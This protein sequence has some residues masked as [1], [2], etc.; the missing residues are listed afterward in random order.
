MIIFQPVAARGSRSLSPKRLRTPT[1]PHE[2]DTRTVNTWFSSAG[3]E[4]I[5]SESTSRY[6]HPTVTKSFEFIPDSE[7]SIWP[8][9][10]LSKPITSSVSKSHF[11]NTD[12]LFS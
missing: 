9:D 6:E 1:S 12:N 5:F 7:W 11:L 2:G 10:N 8:S 4:L 3:I